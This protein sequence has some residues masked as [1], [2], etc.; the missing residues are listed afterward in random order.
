MKLLLPEMFI[1]DIIT[2]SSSEI[3]VCDTDKTVE[4]VEEILQ[5]LYDILYAGRDFREDMTVRR[6]TEDDFSVFY[7]YQNHMWNW[8]GDPDFHIDS[9]IKEAWEK[10]DKSRI[11]IS[12]EDDNSIPFSLFDIIEEVFNAERKHLG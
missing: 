9:Q 3:F 2:N 7:Y 8:E 10:S 5:G 6:I 11:V 12:S 4:T 1:T